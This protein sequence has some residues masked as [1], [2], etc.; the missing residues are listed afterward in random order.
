MARSS[1]IF[2]ELRRRR[3][4]LGAVFAYVLLLNALIAAALNVQAIGAALDPLSAAVTCDSTSSGSGSD[5]IPHNRQHLPDCTL[6]SP[7]CVMGGLLQGLG[8]TVELVATPPSSFVLHVSAH[9]TSSVNPPSVYLSDPDA[10]AP[11]AIA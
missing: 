11:P 3:G 8:S 9:A 5:P 6:C 4:A 7:A 1:G 10:Q 2:R